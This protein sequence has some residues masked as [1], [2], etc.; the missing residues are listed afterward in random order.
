MRS[1]SKSHGPDLRIAGLG[2]PAA[3]LN[4][5]VAR[6]MLGPAWTSRML[7]SIVLDLLTHETSIAEVDAARRTYAERQAALVAALA[8]HGVAVAAPDGINL[9]LPVHDEREAVLHLAAAGV[10]VAGSSPFLAAETD[11]PAVRVTSGLL[12]PDDAP[13]VAAALAAV[14]R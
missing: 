3:L 9:W 14:A 2:G 7:Q 4:R 10:R 5:V 11:R 13:D 12:A 8:A 6:R 1:Y